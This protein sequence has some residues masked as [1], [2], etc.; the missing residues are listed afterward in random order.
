MSLV[1]LVFWWTEKFSENCEGGEG[2]LLAWK[3]VIPVD[4]APVGNEDDYTVL[5]LFK[6]GFQVLS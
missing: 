1:P 3:S 4:L 2:E 6:S 5:H